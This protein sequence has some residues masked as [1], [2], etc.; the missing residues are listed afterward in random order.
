MKRI[1]RNIDIVSTV[2]LASITFILT[3]FIM[4]TLTIFRIISTDTYYISVIILLII[5]VA[6]LSFIVLRCDIF[7]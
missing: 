7:N 6:V 2:A 4:K 1:I 5:Y 3:V